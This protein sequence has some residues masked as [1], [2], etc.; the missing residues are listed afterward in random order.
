MN[1]GDCWSQ[2]ADSA[3]RMANAA[4]SHDW[5]A[6]IDQ[7]GRFAAI[8]ENLPRHQL[9]LPSDAARREREQLIRRVLEDVEAVREQVGPWMTDVRPLLEAWRRSET[10]AP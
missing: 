2:L 5:D 3:Q 7:Y 4:Q 10:P 8:A 1:S 9:P 6:L